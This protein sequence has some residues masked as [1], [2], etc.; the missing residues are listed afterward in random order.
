MGGAISH[1][2]LHGLLN[3]WFRHEFFRIVV[4]TVEGKPLSSLEGLDLPSHEGTKLAEVA[5]LRGLPDVALNEC[6]TNLKVV[7]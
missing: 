3:R 4:I 6:A 7:H 1:V 2:L 5:T